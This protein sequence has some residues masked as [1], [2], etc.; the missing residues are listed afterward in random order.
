MFLAVKEL[1]RTGLLPGGTDRVLNLGRVR[2]FLASPLGRRMAQAERLK[3]EQQFVMGLP[4]RQIRSEYAG[5]HL[6]DETLLVQGIIDAWF[7]EDGEL[8]VVDYKTDRMDGDDR[9]TAR[10]RLSERYRAQLDYY[11]AA[12]EMS[13]GKRVKERY[14]YSFSLEEAILVKQS[15]HDV[16]GG[17]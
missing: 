8:V 16:P 6:E 4:A 2:R 3:K 1:E 11:Q 15:A 12:L 13:T 7:E 17:R 10:R 5:S 9:E 14:I